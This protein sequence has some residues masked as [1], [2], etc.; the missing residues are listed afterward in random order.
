MYL[1]R[2]AI[3]P[4]LP[5]ARNMLGNTYDIH[6]SVMSMFTTYRKDESGRETRR[7]GGSGVPL[8][9]LDTARDSISLLMVSG[10][11]PHT[12]EFAQKYGWDDG[13]DGAVTV[14][15]YDTFLE[16]IRDGESYSFRTTMNM[17]TRASDGRIKVATSYN[18]KTVWSYTAASLNGF[19]I[20]GVPFIESLVDT[21]EKPNGDKVTL[22]KST[23]AGNL[24]V[25]DADALRSAL[26]AG[27]GRGKAYGCG[28]I[29]LAP[30]A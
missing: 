2:I 17:A 15:A 20:K 28:L 6:T 11:K 22:D 12:S 3:N 14:A 18:A 16:S 26:V 10:D 1:S 4:Y 23:V 8:W 7:R 9:R 5:A 29:T 30:P 19:S 21:F 24:I 27:I 13:T 25:T